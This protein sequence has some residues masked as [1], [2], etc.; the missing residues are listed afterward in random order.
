MKLPGKCPRER[1]NR[2][3][4]RPLHRFRENALGAYPQFYCRTGGKSSKMRFSLQVYFFQIRTEGN[5]EEQGLKFLFGKAYPAPCSFWRE[6]QTLFVRCEH[7]Q[8]RG[9][10]VSTHK[11]AASQK[12]L[13]KLGQKKAFMKS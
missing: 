8:T 6:G 5:F 7:S 11:L 9:E 12:L 4:F 2:R 13:T 1:V 10:F 3:R